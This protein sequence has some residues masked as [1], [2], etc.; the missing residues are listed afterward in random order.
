MSSSMDPRFGM[1]RGNIPHKHPESGRM[2]GEN[3]VIR[4]ESSVI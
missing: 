4:K 1:S 2:S 3:H